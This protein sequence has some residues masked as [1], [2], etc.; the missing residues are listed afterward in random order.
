MGAEDLNLKTVIEAVLDAKGFEDFKAAVQ[1]AKDESDKAGAGADK[2]GKEFERLGKRLPHSAFQLLSRDLFTQLGIQGQLGP[3]VNVSTLAMDALARSTGVM[4]NVMTGATL[5]IALLI[6]ILLSMRKGTEDNATAARDL[7]QADETLIES[8]ETV[9]RSTRGLTEEQTQLYKALLRVQQATRQAEMDALQKKIKEATERMD[10]EA[11][12]AKRTFVALDEYGT[13][14]NRTTVNQD[15][16]RL[17]SAKAALEVRNLKDQETILRSTMEG[18]TAATMKQAEALKTDL[19][20]AARKAAEEDRK[21]AQVVQATWDQEEKARQ[22]RMADQRADW[23]KTHDEISAG[24]KKNVSQA[25]KAINDYLDARAD[26]NR[27]ILRADVVMAR[28]DAQRRKAERREF[29][30]DLD[31]RAK[32]YRAAGMSKVDVARWRESKIQ[33]ADRQTAELERQQALEKASLDLEIAAASVALLESQFGPN[34]A[35]AISMAIINTAEGITKAL[36][37]EGW[38]GI[39]HAIAIGIMGAAQINRIRQQ[40]FDKGAGFDDPLNDAIMDA[41]FQNFGRKWAA[42]AAAL[43]TGAASRGF[44]QGMRAFG[45][46]QGGPAVVHQS[47]RIDRGTHIQNLHLGGFFGTNKTQILTKLNR[48]LIRVDRLEDR[49]RRRR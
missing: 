22:I 18:V 46:S 42:D 37:T 47:T 14:I 20:E 34:K 10:E 30:A 31:E 15:K 9:R 38:V 4:A 28:G 16:H 5:G 11:K 1:G 41:A 48:E 45:A 21:V 7:G 23:K 32:A 17:A 29:E 12:A 25:K 35:F 43:A 27:E 24:E 33:A 6:P 36:A 2:S 40:K 49:T 26:A 8:L 19:T 13:E 3:L 44:G 39:A